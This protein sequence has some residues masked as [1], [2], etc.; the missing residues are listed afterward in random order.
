MVGVSTCMS[1]TNPKNTEPEIQT[2]SLSKPTQCSTNLPP[3]L[4]VKQSCIACSNFLLLNRVRGALDT[5]GFFVQK[6][7]TLT[8]PK[9]IA[10]ML[11][12]SDMNIERIT[13]AIGA[14]ISGIDLSRSLNS[15]IAEAVYQALLKH[16][17]LVIPGQDLSAARQLEFAEMFG[18]I[19]QPHHSYPHVDGLPQVTLLENDA[20]RPPDT[21][22]WHADLTF[23]ENPPF[24]SVLH[25]KILPECGGDT[26][27]SSMY[28][29]YER[30][31]DSMKA[32]LAELEA[33]HDPGSF[34][35]SFMGPNKSSKSLD[36]RM[37]EEGS[38]LHPVI[39]VHPGT[40]R[41]YLYVNE[42][43]TMQI[44]GHSMPDS[45]RLLQYL[46]NHINQPEFQFRH[47]WNTG[48]L[49]MWDN[50]VTQHYAVNDYM[51]HYRRMHRVTIIND[52]HT[53]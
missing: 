19:D 52:C 14:T 32:E 5:V 25:S 24:A 44:Y 3:A 28:A 38:A 30:L 9:M 4:C 16:L 40:G 18:E 51:P 47:R 37:Y 45:N 42:G 1:A 12:G 13:P 26:I 46:F 20:D 22:E 7:Q 29:A 17:V 43:F 36:R 41:K 8:G 49:V 21:H 11:Q 48:D 2:S 50:R 35:N 53:G 15:D 27:W 10:F 33:I 39:R 31:T 34:R 23:R 6:W